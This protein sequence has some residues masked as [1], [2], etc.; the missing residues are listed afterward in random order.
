MKDLKENFSNFKQTK[1]VLLIDQIESSFRPS[2][3]ERI[4]NKK[5]SKIDLKFLLGD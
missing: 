1:L 3:C 4:K 2:K 5:V